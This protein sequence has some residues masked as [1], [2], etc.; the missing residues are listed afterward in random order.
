MNLLTLA[1]RSPSTLLSALSHAHLPELPSKTL[2]FALA[3]PSTVT[4]RELTALTDRLT[5]RFPTHVGCIS[6]PVPIGATQDPN[7]CSVS[8]ALV[9]GVPFRST[10]PGRSEPQVGRWH[11]GRNRVASENSTQTKAGGS[12]VLHTVISKNGEVD[13]RKLWSLPSSDQGTGDEFPQDLRY[14]EYVFSE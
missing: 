9:D 3:P 4:P 6:A 10:V 11:A 7:H 2:L 12:D 1:S 13:W 8:L 14:L 5:K